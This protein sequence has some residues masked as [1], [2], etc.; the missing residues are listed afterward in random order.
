MNVGR[1]HYVSSNSQV[2]FAGTGV[3]SQCPAP[4]FKCK[5][6]SVTIYIDNANV[7]S[8]SYAFKIVKYSNGVSTDVTSAI[9]V[10]ASDLVT[11]KVLTYYFGETNSVGKYIPVLNASAN[12][13]NPA[14]GD[15]FG[16]SVTTSSGITTLTGHITWCLAEG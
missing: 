14:T 13:L 7:S 9:S 6:H 3:K 5:L 11:G 4:P 8:P 2:N 1:L 15:A 12:D 16:F 10:S